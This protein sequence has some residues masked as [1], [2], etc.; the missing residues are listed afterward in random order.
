MKALEEAAIQLF[1]LG[2]ADGGPSTTSV[3]PPFPEALADD[4]N[5]PRLLPNYIHS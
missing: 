1:R 5:T 4:L 2:F 3:Y